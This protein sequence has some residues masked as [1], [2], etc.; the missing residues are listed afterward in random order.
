MLGRFGPAGVNLACIIALT[1]GFIA[2]N[3][4][5]SRDPFKALFHLGIARIQIR[6]QLFY[7]LAI[8]L[9]Y[10]TLRGVFANPERFVKCVWHE[11]PSY[12]FA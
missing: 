1:L 6:M 4:I 11:Y 3:I 7:E 2:N 8:G 5:G 10:V 9:F 12:V